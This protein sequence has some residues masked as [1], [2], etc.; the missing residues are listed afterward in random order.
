[1]F[2]ND[3]IYSIFF[4]LKPKE[5]IIEKNF[6]KKFDIKKIIFLNKNIIYDNFC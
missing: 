3:F 6:G 4:S 2:I 5:G 1:M